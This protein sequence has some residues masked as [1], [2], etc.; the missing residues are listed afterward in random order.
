MP[1]KK[2]ITYAE[3][4]ENLKALPP[5]KLNDTATVYVPGVGEFYPVMTTEVLD[6]SQ[7]VLDPGHLVMVV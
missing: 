1:M 3:L 6:V 7:D 4:I 2:A 5:E